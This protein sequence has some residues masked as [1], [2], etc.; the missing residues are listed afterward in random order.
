MLNKLF[1]NI[2]EQC[3]YVKN[4]LPLFNELRKN[5]KTSSKIYS[6][7]YFIKAFAS[8]KFRKKEIHRNNWLDERMRVTRKQFPCFTMQFYAK[9]LPP[10]DD[11]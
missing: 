2:I 5:A 7:G 4:V 8:D 10:G 1:N 6:Q 11:V 3:S 9:E